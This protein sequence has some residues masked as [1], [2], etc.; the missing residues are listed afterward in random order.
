M[1]GQ[2]V[3]YK[4]YKKDKNDKSNTLDTTKVEF[5]SFYEVVNKNK[6]SSIDNRGGRHGS[7]RDDADRGRDA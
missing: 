7:S 6:S 2:R 3:K 5:D 4:K 1:E